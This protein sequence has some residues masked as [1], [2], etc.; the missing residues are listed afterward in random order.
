ML[1]KLVKGVGKF[2]LKVTLPSVKVT[3]QLND[4]PILLVL[5]GIT[6]CNS[7]VG[8]FVFVVLTV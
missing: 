1:L 2:S 6:M 4:T 3:G 8:I 5:R 7:G